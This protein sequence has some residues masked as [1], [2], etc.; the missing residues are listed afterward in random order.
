MYIPLTFTVILSLFRHG[1]FYRFSFD[2]VHQ[3][4]QPYYRN[5][6]SYATIMSVFFPFLWLAEKWYEKG[7]RKYKILQWSKLLYLI[8]IY[9]SYTRGA[10][11]AVVAMLPFYFVI[12][13]N[14]MKTALVASVV[15]AIVGITYVIQNNYY[16]RFAPTFKR[17]VMHEKLGDHFAS[18]FEGEDL[19]SMER[20][21]R[22][23]AAVKMIPE[24]PFM[25]TGSGNF[26]NYYKR[27]VAYDFYTY[28]SENPERSTV[29]DYF[30][31]VTIEQGFIGL[32][33]F[34]ALTFAIFL[35][36]NNIYR[37]KSGIEKQTA[38]VLLQSMFS[39][40]VCLLLNDML[41]TDKIGSFFFLII[42]L[43]LSLSLSRIS[44]SK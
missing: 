36:G 29:H 17:T 4:I 34:V 14:K 26:Y 21:Y 7:S 2:N 42:G 27:Y 12:K 22:W 33:I 9:F 25:G 38:L 28:V 13:W 1:F 10:M 43:F 41:E 11:L 6:V 40:Y 3:S 35:T 16:F 44:F 18:T 30:L 19:S 8:A 31:Y 23:V 24:R 32:V 20:V 39:I 15:V 5:H 37:N